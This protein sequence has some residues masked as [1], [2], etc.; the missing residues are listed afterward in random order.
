MRGSRHGL[1]DPAE[2]SH[3]LALDEA[4]GNVHLARNFRR[5]Q[6]STA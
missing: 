1:K 5:L 2:P 4:D 6:S 3:R